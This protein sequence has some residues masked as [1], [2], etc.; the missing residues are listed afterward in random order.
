MGVSA[1]SHCS[2]AK[3]DFTA[4]MTLFSYFGKQAGKVGKGM[5]EVLAQVP[6]QLAQ[7]FDSFI[8]AVGSHITV[9]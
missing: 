9:L 2:K 7:E 5:V 1:L 6:N 4:R 8:L 3:F